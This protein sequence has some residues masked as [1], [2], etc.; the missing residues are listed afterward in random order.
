MEITRR[1]TDDYLELRLNGRFDAAW[2]E[3]VSDAID[4]AIREGEHRIALDF[5]AVSYISS[6]GIGVLLMHHNRLK[7]VQ[8]HLVVVRPTPATLAVIRASGLTEDLLRVDA[9][10]AETTPERPPAR[11]VDHADATYEIYDQLPGATFE[12]TLLGDPSKFGA[13]GFA[14][15]DCRPMEL[16]DGLVALG[17][18]AFGDGFADCK[19][20]FGEFLAVGGGAV[21]QP[22]A[23]Q[24]VPDYQVTRGKLVP[25]VNA[26]YAIAANGRFAHMLRFDDDP[27][28]LGLIRLSRL[29]ESALQL[30]NADAACFTIVA[31]AAS[32]IGATLRRSP[33]TG[34]KGRPHE[35][36]DVRDWLSFTTERATDRHLV[37]IAGIAAKTPPPDAAP[38]LRP[39]S[40]GSAILGHFHAAVFP[41]LPV[42]RGE[43]QI[44][45]TVSTLLAASAPRTVRHLM[46]DVRAFEGVGETEV[47]RGACWVG[48]IANMRRA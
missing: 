41:Y 33:V 17:L 39:M 20:R 12:C 14:E 26:L 43:L 6:L 2:A 19:A 11:T 31:E 28:K 38:F 13:C 45:T 37:L 35:F 36:P 4:E 47:I 18:G 42:Q 29:V 24:G 9:A 21:T 30:T 3:F 32:V 16:P 40:A 1:E 27:E 48:P 23:E 22:T 8:G 5:E 25:K 46:A 15:G 44:A 7:L 10:P 34:A